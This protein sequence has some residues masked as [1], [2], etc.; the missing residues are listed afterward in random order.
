M[1]KTIA[2][3]T[4][5]PVIIFSVVFSVAALKKRFRKEQLPSEER[6]SVS[7]LKASAKASPKSEPNPVFYT[8]VGGSAP[9]DDLP[10]VSKKIATRYTI[11]LGTVASQTDAES[12]LLRLKDRGIDGFY[13]PMRRSGK[14]VY[15][16]RVGLYANQDDAEQSLK[17]FATRANVKGRVT[18]L[19]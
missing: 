16:V 7:E 14:V 17:K 13:T 12:L 18:K 4:L 19:H 3:A 2:I 9:S 1:K 8:N 11:E 5:A 15:H 10:V 6:Q